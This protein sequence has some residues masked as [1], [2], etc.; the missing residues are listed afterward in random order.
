MLGAAGTFVAEYLR[1]AFVVDVGEEIGRG[2]SV[3]CK[4]ELL[5]GKTS[6]ICLPR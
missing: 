2:P 4:A 3:G 5:V 1:L 6:R